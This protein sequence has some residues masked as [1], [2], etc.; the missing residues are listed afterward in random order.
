MYAWFS[1]Y[2]RTSTMSMVEQRSLVVYAALASFDIWFVGRCLLMHSGQHWASALS[3][4]CE[5]DL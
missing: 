5:S 3:H 1:V 4:L 2:Q